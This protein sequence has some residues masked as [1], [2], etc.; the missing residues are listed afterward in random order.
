MYSSIVTVGSEPFPVRKINNY[1]YH[2]DDDLPNVLNQLYY[3]EGPLCDHQ[4]SSQP[5]VNIQL[6][7]SNYC[8]V[9][10]TGAEISL[11]SQKV[12]DGLI[13]MG[14][15]LEVTYINVDY[16]IVGLTGATIA[17]NRVIEISFNIGSFEMSE[18]HRFAIIPD[19][20]MPF[21]LLLGLDFI[22]KFR[23]TLDLCHRQCKID[24]GVISAFRGTGV[25]KL[26]GAILIV[27][28]DESHGVS[29]T[30]FVDHDDKDNV[31]RFELAQQ[32]ETVTGVSIAMD[33]VIVNFIQSADTEIRCV[34]K[35]I[36]N[37]LLLREWPRKV[38]KFKRQQGN[39][40][41][42]DGILYCKDQTAVPVVSFKFML[43]LAIFIHCNFG[44]I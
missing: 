38:Q 32:S 4:P 15:Q 8:A 14:F 2:M 22:T 29:H 31:L 11:I 17:I 33:P 10:D 3:V 23:I 26:T 35:C 44:H 7:N 28:A 39:L 19:Y 12:V 36:M 1:Y 40:C 18:S 25:N 34:R 43:D 41:V 30:V 16:K 6:F 9:L 37:S 21:C 13:Q 24:N 27:K 5:V 20:V 42:H